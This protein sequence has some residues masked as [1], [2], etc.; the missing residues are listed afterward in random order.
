MTK[1]K[2]NKTVSNRTARQ[3]FSGPELGELLDQVV[4]EL[5]PAA[6]ISEV[7]KIRSGGVAGFFCREEYEIIV[8]AGQ[9]G[10]G[11]QKQPV[12]AAATA[13]DSTADH[14]DAGDEFTATSDPVRNIVAD[15][16]DGASEVF[17]GPRPRAI[18][19]TDERFLALL[20]RR[21]EETSEAEVRS[22]TRRVR[23]PAPRPTRKLPDP[24][25]RSELGV[26][27]RP[28]L[29]PPTAGKTAPAS[30]DFA[31]SETSEDVG[32]DGSHR[33]L[34]NGF[35][36]RISMAR[37]QL[38]AVLPSP[39]SFL[40]VIGPLSLTTPVI[41][42]LRT[43]T[44]LASADVIVLT[45]RA[46]IVSEPNWQLVRSGHQLIELANERNGGPTLLV[47][48]VPVE[49][50]QWVAPLQQRLRLAGVGAFRYA[51]PGT[52]SSEQL[53]RYRLGSDVPYVLDLVSRV[54]PERLVAFLSQQHPIGSIGGATLTAELLVAMQEQV[55]VGW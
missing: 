55:G 23:R 21:L 29:E 15:G 20:E 6:E 41:R 9:T 30:S 3:R 53:D 4:T 5:G 26:E 42:R 13:A 24:E 35:W 31:L 37:D 45:D 54:E 19:G 44:D 40:A 27:P 34:A 50:P 16:P 2:Q 11:P 39:S 47:V 8:D 10:T 22:A 49:L 25:P 33:P 43:E 1:S 46:E 51:V 17:G 18:N 52:P 36:A 14:A 38:D 48:D 12:V 7:N 28:A 32:S